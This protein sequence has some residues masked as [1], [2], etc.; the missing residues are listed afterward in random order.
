ML[1]QSAATSSNFQPRA[2]LSY[3]EKAERVHPGFPALAHGVA[4]C[5]VAR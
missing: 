4:R 2:S 3:R 1:V 5:V